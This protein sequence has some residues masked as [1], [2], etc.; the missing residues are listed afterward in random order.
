MCK[1]NCSG[2]CIECS[3]KD[4]LQGL[5]ENILNDPTYSLEDKVRAKTLIDITNDLITKGRAQLWGMELVLTK[6]QEG[7][8][9]YYFNDTAD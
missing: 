2:G 5:P 9:H 7:L 6:T 4:H 1:I 3:P 8:D